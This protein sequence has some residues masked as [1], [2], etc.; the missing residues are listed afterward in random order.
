MTYILKK[1]ALFDSMDTGT[2]IFL[3]M[4]D[5]YLK[6]YASTR[7]K[8]ITVG[9]SEAS[10]VFGRIEAVDELGRVEFRLND[11]VS[12]QLNIPGEH[13]F[14]N[15]LLA[16]AVGIFYGIGE[17]SI[18]DVLEA[19][20]PASQRMEMVEKE[21]VLFVNDAYNANPNSMCA[22]VDYL[23]KIQRPGG[24]RIL[25]LGDMLELGDFAKSEHYEL[26]KY[27]AKKAIDVVLLYGPESKQIQKGIKESSIESVEAIWYKSHE[28]IA[29]YLQK[30]LEKK[31]V[32]LLKGSRGMQMEKVLELLF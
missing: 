19:F 32:V 15:A 25:V 5:E 21:D 26:G 6:K 28:K 27:I 24:K 2:A 10:D 17:S 29:N 30:T 11:S 18:K 31:D 12:I 20:T 4:E 3:N 14:M 9:F 7:R 22:A 13:N 23:T 16:S 8:S 1:T